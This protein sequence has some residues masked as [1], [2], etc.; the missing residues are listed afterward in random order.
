M[1]SRCVLCWRNN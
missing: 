1:T